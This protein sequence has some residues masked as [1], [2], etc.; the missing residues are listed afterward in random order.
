MCWSKKRLGEAFCKRKHNL[1]QRLTNYLISFVLTKQRRILE[2]KLG[3][4]MPGDRHRFPRCP[5]R[6]LCSLVTLAVSSLVFTAT[7]TAF[8][9]TLYLSRIC[10][11]KNPIRSTCD[12]PT[13]NSFLFCSALSSYELG[14][15]CFL[16]TLCLS[17]IS[18]PGH[19]MLPGFWRS[20]VFRHVPI[21][22]KRLNNNTIAD[23]DCVFYKGQTSELENL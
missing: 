10:R 21:S 1:C 22:R 8:C 3:L 17:T 7:D 23:E 16:A 11:S 9:Y 20:V 14:A 5:L 18:G 6:S 12:H 13:Q 2:N 19:G 4:P 15:S